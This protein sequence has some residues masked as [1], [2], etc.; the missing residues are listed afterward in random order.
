M[1]TTGFKPAAASPAA[2]VTACSSA[3]P[4]SKNRSGKLLWNRFKP[5]PTS[6]AA[7]TATTFGSRSPIFLMMVEK[8][9]VQF[10]FTRLFFGR[11]VAISKGSAPW[12]LAGWRSAG[13]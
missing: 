6:M 2:K 8:T 13:A 4:T 7:V 9:S 3:M 11:P 10:A 1:A 5:V 12:N